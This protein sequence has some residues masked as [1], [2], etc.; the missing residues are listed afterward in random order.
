MVTID[1]QPVHI[2]TH[3]NDLQQ[4]LIEGVSLHV[5]NL[6]FYMYLQVV[7]SQVAGT[8][9]AAALVVVAVIALCVVPS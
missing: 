3:D 4:V 6:R 8:L 9:A 5:T 7:P 1:N 2:M